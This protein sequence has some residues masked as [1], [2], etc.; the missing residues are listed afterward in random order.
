MKED[1]EVVVVIK[2]MCLVWM[3]LVSDA[4]TMN[5][6]VCNEVNHY[7]ATNIC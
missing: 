5:F 6:Y 7:S 4:Y 1:L 3:N 2:I